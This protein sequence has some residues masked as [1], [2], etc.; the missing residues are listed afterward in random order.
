MG[1]LKEEL[2]LEVEP[3]FI[4]YTYLLLLML[5]GRAGAIPSM[6]WVESGVSGTS[7]VLK[8]K[9]TAGKLYCS[10]MKDSAARRFQVGPDS[11]GNA[12]STALIWSCME[13]F[14]IKCRLN[15]SSAAA[16]TSDI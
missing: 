1:N 4:F 2:R 10:F 12:A 5:G 3:A 13:G 15:E 8:K 16:A 7:L 9:K 11:V 14:Q 6:L